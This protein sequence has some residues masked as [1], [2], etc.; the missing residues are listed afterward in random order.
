MYSYTKDNN[1]NERT[2][3]GIKKYVIKKNL[4]HQ[5]YN[6]T[7]FNNKQTYHE[8]KTI[9]SVYH[10]LGSYELNKITLSCFDDKRFVHDNGEISCAYG[11]YKI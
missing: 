11:H 9:R 4:Q 1:K 8:M 5:D 3:K 10:Q 2:A 7:L 6:D